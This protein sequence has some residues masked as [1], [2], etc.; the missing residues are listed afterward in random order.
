MKYAMQSLMFGLIFST[1]PMGCASNNA[2]LLQPSGT[3]VLDGPEPIKMTAP[4]NGQLMVYDV[5]DDQTIW[6]GVVKKG[7][8]LVL[9]PVNKQL[10]LDGKACNVEDLKSGHT[11]R[12]SFDKT[13]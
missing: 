8:A 11:F 13:N 2:N 1:L 9:D 12:L 3:V 4:D 5:G 10:T 7:Q 6:T